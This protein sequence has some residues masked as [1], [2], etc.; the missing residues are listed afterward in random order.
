VL[1]ASLGSADDDLPGDIKAVLLQISGETQGER[2]SAAVDIVPTHGHRLAA[3]QRSQSS[4][5]VRPEDKEEED[6]Q[7]QEECQSDTEVVDWTR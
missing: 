4:S 7:Q 1:V 3:F 5:K 6:E 2:G